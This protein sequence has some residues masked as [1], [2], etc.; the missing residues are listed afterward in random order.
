MGEQ[1]KGVHRTGKGW[2]GEDWPGMD[3]K[4]TEWNGAPGNGMER[5]GKFMVFEILR[6]LSAIKP[7]PAMRS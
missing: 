5:K 6:F 4:G 2:Q 7:R 3:Q 1:G